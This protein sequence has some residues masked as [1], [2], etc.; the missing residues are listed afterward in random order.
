MEKEYTLSELSDI[1]YLFG[2]DIRMLH[3]HTVGDEFFSL[4]ENLG[5]LYQIAFDAYD[6]I[7]EMAISHDEPIYNP[8]TALE[9]VNWNELNDMDYTLENVVDYIRTNGADVMK[10]IE[11]VKKYESFVQSKIDSYSEDLDSLIN[12]KF[13]QLA[14]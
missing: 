4:H 1:L 10:C 14:K 7:A 3:L 13:G 5:D 8:S 6:S 12:Y 11:N 2:N 9:R